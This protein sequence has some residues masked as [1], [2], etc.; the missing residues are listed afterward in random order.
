MKLRIITV[1]KPKLKFITPGVEM[2]LKRL[3][4]YGV[5]EWIP[6]KAGTPESEGPLL[7]KASAAGVRVVLDERGKMITSIQ[8]AEKVSEW[9]FDAAREVNFLIGGADGHTEEVKAAADWKW[10]LSSLTLQHEMALLLLTEQLYRAQT[11]RR[12]EPYHRS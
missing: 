8:L 12:G 7:L 2:Y 3:A 5:C 10:S 4:P 11:I 1:G 9:E 6:V